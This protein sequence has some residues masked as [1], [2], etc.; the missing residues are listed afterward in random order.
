MNL[1]CIIS[2]QL[3]HCYA[4]T[5]LLQEA[6]EKEQEY[7]SSLQNMVVVVDEVNSDDGKAFPYFLCHWFIIFMLAY[8]SVHINCV[9]C[10]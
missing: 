8:C 6:V 5:Q 9:H 1:N 3:F 4:S 10:Q 2:L 7:V